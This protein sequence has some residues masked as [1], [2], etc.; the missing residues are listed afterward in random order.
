M[1]EDLQRLR[2]VE[3]LR[4]LL[5]RY[6]QLGTVDKDAWQDRLMQ[7][8]GVTASDL[9][10]L[11]GELLAYSWIEQ[12]TG[13]TPIVRPGAVPFCYRIT[14]AGRRAIERATI[15]QS[16]EDSEEHSAQAA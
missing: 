15:V 7:V 1:F 11:H 3:T 12:N 9:T 14:S 4:Q 5:A 8:N 6:A 16:E 13:V 10:K 2:E